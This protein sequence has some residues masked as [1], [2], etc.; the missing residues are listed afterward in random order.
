TPLG[1]PIEAEALGEVFGSGRPADRP[2]IVGS[3][4]TNLAHLEAAAGIAGLI[5]MV[6][7]LQH[8]TIPPLLH[9]DAPNPR[10]DWRGLPVELPRRPRSWPRHGRQRVAGISAFGLTGTIAHLVLGDPPTAQPAV[11]P[12]AAEPDLHVLPLSARSPTALKALQARHQRA[13]ELPEISLPDYCFTAG[14]GRKPQPYRLAVTGRDMRSLQTALAEA[15]PVL[16]ES[17]PRLAFLF[18][19]QGAHWRGMGAALLTREPVFRATVERCAAALAQEPAF[20]HRS[21]LDLLGPDG[22]ELDNTA[23]AQPSLFALQAGLVALWKSWGVVPDIVLGH[24]AGEIAAAVAAGLIGIEDGVRFAARRGAAM[25]DMPTGAMAAVFSPASEVAA[26]IAAQQLPLSIAACN[27][28]NETVVSG[29]ATAI[30]ALA[31]SGPKTKALAVTYAFHSAHVDPVLE[32]IA[33]AAGFLAQRPAE[34]TLLCN[35]DGLTLAPGQRLPRDYWSR[36]ARA[37]VAFDRALAALAAAAP[38]ACIEIGPRP[39]LLPLVRRSGGG[40]AGIP[41]LPSLRADDT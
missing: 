21:L 25:A 28:P 40:L 8:D 36:Q 16:A 34:R 24:S 29:D 37:P 39:T 35:L 30:A 7:A 5:K 4:K 18:T 41:C 3:V 12:A 13:L 23:L 1:D 38:T 20:R 26:A 11:D 15:V 2:L 9:Q 6:L 19:G 17:R 32:R 22:E 27:G 31:D 33:I 14:V 10:L